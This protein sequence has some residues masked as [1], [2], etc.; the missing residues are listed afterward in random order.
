MVIALGKQ[1]IDPER[2]GDAYRQ[3]DGA[4]EILDVVLVSRHMCRTVCIEKF[5]A[6]SYRITQE[7]PALLH[8][9]G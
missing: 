9:I 8:E 1:S 7:F 4:D 6:G 2:A 5:L 3:F